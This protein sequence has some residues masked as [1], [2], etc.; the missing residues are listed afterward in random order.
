MASRWVALVEIA[1]YD[2]L[3]VLKG[4]AHST[5]ATKLERTFLGWRLKG[6]Q[7]LRSSFSNHAQKST[8]E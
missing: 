4:L 3:E 1:F 7:Q 8:F 6:Q 2:V 5:Q